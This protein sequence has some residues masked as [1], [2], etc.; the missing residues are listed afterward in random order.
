MSEPLI[1]IPGT[2]TVSESAAVL[3]GV[4]YMYS[5][6]GSSDSIFRLDTAGEY[7]GVFPMIFFEYFAHVDH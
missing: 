1:F 7:T 3:T 2:Y 4:S 6:D 5:W